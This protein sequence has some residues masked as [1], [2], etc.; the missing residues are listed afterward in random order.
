LRGLPPALPFFRA[1]ETLAAL[2]DLP[3]VAP[4]LPAI[5]RFD[6]KTPS[7]S[8]GMYKSASSAGK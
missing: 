1:A 8:A 4:S 6:P 7:N 2:L 3:P 5:H